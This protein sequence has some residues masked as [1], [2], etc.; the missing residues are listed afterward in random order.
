L[1]SPNHVYRVTFNRHGESPDRS[2]A[3]A[4][5]R[6]DPHDGHFKPAVCLD[7]FTSSLTSHLGATLAQVQVTFSVLISFRR[8]FPFAGLPSRLSRTQG[9]AIAR[10]NTIG[11]IVFQAMIVMDFV[12]VIM[13]VA[14]LKPLRQ[15][16][17]NAST[18]DLTRAAHAR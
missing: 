12:A 15:R 10:C 9:P 14:V 6:T 16:L 3:T 13:A 8:F 7:L 1:L 18:E 2:L 4:I 17:G 11:T 5:F